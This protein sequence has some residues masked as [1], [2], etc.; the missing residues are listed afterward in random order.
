MNSDVMIA[1][2]FDAVPD[3]LV[4][5]DGQGRIVRANGN[6]ERLFGYQPGAL[7]GLEI[8]TLLPASARGRHRTHRD[9]YMAQ[10]HVRPMGASGQTLDGLRRDGTVFPV[11]IALSPLASDEGTRYLA[12][13]RD[14]SDTQ[15]E[16]QALVRARYDAVVARIGQLALEAPGETA[17]IEALPP[18]LAEAL[19]VE[20][21]AI[22]LAA[23][24]GLTV[25]VR[26]AVG[27]LWSVGDTAVS[28]AMPATPI[29]IQDSAGEPQLRS[30]FLLPLPAAG[31]A[32]LMPLL[33]RRD[34]IGALVAAA[35]EPRRFDHDAQ[36]LL[37]S[38]ANL[39]SAFLQQRRAEEQLAHSQR[40]DAVGQL[41]GGI[42]H[43]FNNLLT[44]LSGSLQLLE[45]ECDSADARD[46]I[47]SALRSVGRGAELTGK[48]LAFARRQRLMPQAV[49]VHALLQDVARMLGRTLGDAIRLEI[50]GCE[51]LPPAYADPSQ[52]EAALVN[53]AL[54]ARDAMLEGAG[55]IAIKADE[56]LV[57]AGRSHGGLPPGDYVR[58]I[59]T[60]SGRGMSAETLARAMEPFFTTK[61]AGRG[62]GLGL[63]MVYGF[64]RQS[65]GGLHIDSALGRG[66]RVALYLPA[67]RDAAPMQRGAAT[68]SAGGRGESILVVEDDAAVCTIAVSFL[69]A[70]GYRVRAVATAEEALQAL[71]E[72]PG[73]DL[74][75]SDVMLGPGMN[76]K[77]LARQALAEAPALAVLLTSGF[78][79]SAD[80]ADAG[81]EL[82]RK[83]YR[84][85]Q[86]IAA[87][88][89]I[90]EA[91][92][93]RRMDDI[94]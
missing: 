16:R 48:L 41:T 37:R 62:S 61:E 18:L 66:T 71:R 64:A 43:D 45:T 90:L 29:T 75:F 8:E 13:V 30:A 46:L 22:V 26:A 51:N 57:G 78:E 27:P 20:S 36:H 38:L 84:R 52:L 63:S 33:D 3:A 12:S 68:N 23:R 94:G 14:I 19:G 35:R 24:E 50:A 25:E 79:E 42:A 44:V 31:S 4:V 53:L 83:P 54:N 76:G 55:E 5:V 28:K 70:S 47:A 72:D 92:T 73:I 77:A 82:L 89:R 21:V 93:T 69:R 7:T 10:P 6:A 58:I 88:A 39:L 2:L 9:R 60:D 15:R 65:R 74:L 49:D 59:V 86:L 67:A 91:R 11:E 56:A 32:A 85:E 87:V 40:L 81:F 80:D 17:V 1:G 34:A